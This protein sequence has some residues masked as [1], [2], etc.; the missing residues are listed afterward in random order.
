LKRAL[1]A[2]L[3]ALGFVLSLVGIYAVA[4][5]IVSGALLGPR[6]V[7]LQLLGYMA[8]GYL[9]LLLWRTGQRGWASLRR[10]GRE[11]AVVG[12]PDYSGEGEEPV[13]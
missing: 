11:G 12:P 6:V 7:W 13:E 10:A 1:Y 5:T 3:I 4:V 9:G 2:L 8:L